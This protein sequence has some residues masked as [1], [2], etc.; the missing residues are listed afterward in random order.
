MKH[1]E[2]LQAV[3]TCMSADVPLLIHGKPGVGKSALVKSVAAEYKMELRDIR[4]ALLDPVDVMG[5][6]VPDRETR[7]TNWFTP[8]LWPSKGKG[9]LFLDE[10]PQATVAVQK[11]LSQLV[12]DRTIGTSYKLPKGWRILA[13]GN[14]TTDRAGAG[15]LL[16]QM[17]NRFIHVD[18]ETDMTEWINFALKAN[19]MPEI[20]AF[21]R[22]RPELLHDMDVTKN[23]F[24]TPR[25]WEFASDI[26]KAKPSREIEYQLL[27]GT[28]GEGAAA[29]LLG[30]LKIFR[31]LPDPDHILLDPMNAEVP[32]D[33]ATLYALTGALASRASESNFERI[34]QYSKRIKPEFSVL[35]VRDSVTKCP[36]ATKTIAFVNWASE[37][38]KVII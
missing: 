16:S 28:I 19:I 24:P 26:L 10:L 38:H 15:E 7:E 1:S 9:I 32:E 13:A 4:A 3:H 36:E 11:A 23:A 33:P 35:M 20:I 12:L 22:Y 6:P 37:N 17:K 21:I 29:E 2:V 8:E 34:V 14:Y 27:I 25:S 5:V 18:Y 30:F 31:T